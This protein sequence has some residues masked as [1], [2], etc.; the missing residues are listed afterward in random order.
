MLRNAAELR[1]MGAQLSPDGLPIAGISGFETDD[2]DKQAGFR[3]F[4]E[5]AAD[6]GKEIGCVWW[7]SP[8]GNSTDN[9]TCKSQSLVSLAWLAPHA[10]VFITYPSRCK[11]NLWSPAT[12]SAYG[13]NDC[14]LMLSAVLYIEDYLPMTTGS[15]YAIPINNHT[16]KVT[17]T[18]IVPWR[19]M[20]LFSWRQHQIDLGQTM[21]NVINN[22]IAKDLLAIALGANDCAMEME[23]ASTF[24]K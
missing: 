3:C 16:H 1:S 15:G 21:R 5:L 24:R 8:Q 6:L 10:M 7:G 4:K 17:D 12:D 19:M 20:P 9:Y 11:V 22:C 14:R 18:F 13:P 2:A 23:I